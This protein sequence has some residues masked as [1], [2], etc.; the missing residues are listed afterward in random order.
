MSRWS[1]IS[2]G[3]RTTLFPGEASSDTERELD[4]QPASPVVPVAA[5]PPRGGAANSMDGPAA[6]GGGG[7][8]SEHA[9]TFSLGDAAG[10]TLGDIEASVVSWTKTEQGVVVYNIEVRYSD[11][12]GRKLIRRRY[13]DFL[14]LHET[15]KKHPEVAS[16]T[17]PGKISLSSEAEVA[18]R[19]R[20]RFDEY[21]KLVLGLRKAAPEVMDWILSF[22]SDDGIMFCVSLGRFCAH[23][24][25]D[26]D[27]VLH[28]EAQ[29]L[30][31]PAP[32][33]VLIQVCASVVLPSDVGS[34]KGVCHPL[35]RPPCVTGHSFCGMV[36]DGPL[37]LLGKVSARD[38]AWAP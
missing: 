24:L 12:R 18:K 34:I 26:L 31:S 35:P 8:G 20:Q 14:K 23:D 9:R 4:A 13:S 19:R 36:V 27:D 17:F 37:D 30:P 11:G 32:S 2:S 33:E 10:S 1:L 7:R 29:P 38:G 21:L 6:G 3:P 15:L 16:F 25:S 28:I 22:S 5:S